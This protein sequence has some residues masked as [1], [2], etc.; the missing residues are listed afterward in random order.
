MSQTNIGDE[1]IMKG[2]DD[3]ITKRCIWFTLI[4]GTIFA[5]SANPVFADSEQVAEGEYEGVS[6]ANEVSSESVSAIEEDYSFSDTQEQD[7]NEEKDDIFVI[8]M[9]ELLCSESYTESDREKADSDA[10]DA[11]DGDGSDQSTD[12]RP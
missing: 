6:T 7:E 2:D 3:S 8:T 11:Q 9:D 5:L 1:I 12:E 4:C 10:S